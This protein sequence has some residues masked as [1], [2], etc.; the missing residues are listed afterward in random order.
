MPAFYRKP[1]HSTR[2]TN[3]GRFDY[4][5]NARCLVRIGV[6]RL[7][8][9]DKAL[10]AITQAHLRAPAWNLASDWSQRCVARTRAGDD[11]GSGQFRD[12]IRSFQDGA[13]FKGR[14]VVDSR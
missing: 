11:S 3:Q 9:R 4:S 2:T 10:Q 7:Y 12:Y 13:P 6:E 8:L 1:D 5:W 14:D